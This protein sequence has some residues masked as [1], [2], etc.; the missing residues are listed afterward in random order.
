MAHATLTF[1]R[2]CCRTRHD[3]SAGKHGWN[4]LHL[5]GGKS[6]ESAFRQ[7]GPHCRADT[8][9]VKVEMIWNLRQV[10][11]NKDESLAQRP[12]RHWK[13]SAP[14]Q[15]LWSHVPMPTVLIREALYGSKPGHGS[16][17]I[18]G[19]GAIFLN[20]SEA[21]TPAYRDGWL[22]LPSKIAFIQK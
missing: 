22:P 17:T 8:K 5:D 1:P 2:A 16:R 21:V 12:R 13:L 9:K 14:V 3:V 7:V 19:P 6:V 11:T 15:G 4:H 20:G 10:R 18:R